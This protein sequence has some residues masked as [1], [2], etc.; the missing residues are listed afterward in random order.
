MNELV[1]KMIETHGEEDL[2]MPA[3]ETI[4][5]MRRASI[6]SLQRWL[7]IGFSRAA[8][9]MDILEEN[10]IVSPPKNREPREILVDLDVSTNV[11]SEDE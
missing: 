4:R 1:K 2:L 8:R 7:R 9:I 11:E 6:S 5:I 3:V 10:G